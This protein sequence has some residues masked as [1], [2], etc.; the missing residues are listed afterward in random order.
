MKKL[1]SFLAVLAL[2]T[3]LCVP[4]LAA[5]PE[6]DYVTDAACLLSGEEWKTLE[7]KAES[8]SAQY[9]CGVYIITV[10]DFTDYVNTNDVYEA[11]KAIYREYSLG[12]GAEKSGVLLMLSMAERDYSLIAYGYGNTAFTDYGKDRLADRFLD[13]FGDNDWYGGFEDYLNMC[14]SMLRSAREGRPLDVGS[15][16][17][18]R[19]AGIVISVVLGCIAS[20]IVCCFLSLQMKS[21]SVKAEADSYIRSDSINFIAREDRFSHTSQVRTKV[22]SSSGGSGGGTTVDSSGFSGKS[23]KF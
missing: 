8:I 13:N 23:G 5:E 2:L 21:V 7:A 1:I 12:W 19:L 11:A 22:E 4:A 14:E 9:E 6:L 17:T 16:P 10:D 20:F 18:I 3:A 15:A